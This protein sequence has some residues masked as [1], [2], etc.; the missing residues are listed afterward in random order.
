MANGTQEQSVVDGLLE[1][2][3]QDEG[4]RLENDDGFGEDDAPE[5]GDGAGKPDGEKPK[6]EVEDPPAEDKPKDLE[7]ELATL[8]KRFKDTQRSWHEEHQGRLDSDKRLADMQAQLDALSAKKDAGEQG[9]GEESWLSQSERGLLAKIEARI[10]KLAAAM[11]AQQ[12]R[13]GARQW[14]AAEKPV[15]EAHDDYDDV[16]YSVFK[17]AYDKDEALQAEFREAGGTPQ[18]AYEIGQRLKETQEML[19]DPVAYREKLKN[20]LKQEAEKGTQGGE[21]GEPSAGM[22]ERPKPL[23]GVNSQSPKKGAKAPF[24]S[25]YGVLDEVFPSG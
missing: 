6:A 25:A 9:D 3:D 10:D 20:E 2:T 19:K 8:E 14:D 4:E 13:E 24:P 11:E 16:V 23:A 7:A 17:P 21:D 18:A 12:E 15:K 5:E 22:T 1:F